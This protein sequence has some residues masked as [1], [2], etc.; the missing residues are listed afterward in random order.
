MVYEI[1]LAC[2]K[3]ANRRTV[4]YRI[5]P[6]DILKLFSLQIHFISTT[7]L[8]VGIPI[9]LLSLEFSHKIERHF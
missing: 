8:S 3:E 7:H 9:G 2:S 1:T 5:N 6:V 4:F